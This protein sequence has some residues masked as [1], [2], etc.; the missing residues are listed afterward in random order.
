MNLTGRGIFFDFDG[1][2]ADSVDVKTRAFVAIYADHGPEITAKVEAYHLANA[3]M[4]RFHKF[5][6]F[7]REFVRGPDDEATIA[8]LADRFALEVKNRVIA[9]AEIRGARAAL[10][11]LSRHVPLFV[12]SATPEEELGEIVLARGLSRYFAGVHGFP[13]SKSEIL[14]DMLAGHTLDPRRCIMVGA[15]RADLAAAMDNEVAF[16]GVVP[17]GG[18]SPFPP[19]TEIVP[20]LFGF[21]EERLRR[22]RA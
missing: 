3:G 10:E 4:S 16:V 15:A 6:H 21:A 14:R 8:A 5:A 17:A 1:V 22:W 18:K 7:Q 12:A 11:E 20:D 13:R 19:D 9:A 2:I